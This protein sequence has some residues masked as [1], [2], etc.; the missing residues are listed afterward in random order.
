MDSRRKTKKGGLSYIIYSNKLHV[1]VK[2]HD[3]PEHDATRHI[4]NYK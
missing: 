2:R 4:M 1:V 3:H